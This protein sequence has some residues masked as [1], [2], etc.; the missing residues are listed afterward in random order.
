MPR[1]ACGIPSNRQFKKNNFDQFGPLIV[2]SHFAQTYACFP[3]SRNLKAPLICVCKLICCTAPVAVGNSG[4]ASLR[5]WWS[6]PRCCCY[7]AKFRLIRTTQS[8][9]DVSCSKHQ[10]S[11]WICVKTHQT[12]S[13]SAS[14]LTWLRVRWRGFYY[15]WLV[16]FS[17][18]GIL[19]VSHDCPMSSLAKLQNY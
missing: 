13:F 17:A 16:M 14:L 4:A 8:K 19:Y 18:S 10:V 12:A 7:Q 5:A 15:R 3:T 1:T 11:T 6:R 2:S 9:C